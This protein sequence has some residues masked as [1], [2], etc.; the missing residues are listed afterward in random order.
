MDELLIHCP[1]CSAPVR[2]NRLDER[3]GFHYK[4]ACKSCGKTTNISVGVH[5]WN[6]LLQT[7]CCGELLWAANDRHLEW[8][9]DFVSA[10]IRP[11]RRPNGGYYNPGLRT[12]M[13]NWMKSAKNRDELLKGLARLR[14]LF[15]K[16]SKSL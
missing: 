7:P 6:P 1:K 15:D 13:P 16:A 11:A 12:R 5:D 9:E 2:T 3:P 14:E 4:V 8:L 10:G